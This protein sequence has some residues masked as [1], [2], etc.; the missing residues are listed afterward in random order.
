MKNYQIIVYTEKPTLEHFFS[1]NYTGEVMHIT[2]QAENAMQA[3]E[4]AK[5]QFPMYELNPFI[6]EC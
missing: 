3:F 4:Q 1:G 5:K 2:I 6:Q